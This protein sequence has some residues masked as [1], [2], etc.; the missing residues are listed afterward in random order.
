M[1][2]D[3]KGQNI[4]KE[5]TKIS[6]ET[7][8]QKKKRTERNISQDDSMAVKSS[9]TEVD[10]LSQSQ[11][12]SGGVV[13]QTDAKKTEE[14]CI[15]Q[16]K[17]EDS[18]VVAT[19]S[20]AKEPEAEVSHT[21]IVLAEEKSPVDTGKRKK[22]GTNKKKSTKTEDLPKLLRK[23]YSKRA[24]N[25]RI[26][27]RLY[28]ISDK[29][30]VESQFEEVT[31]GKKVKYM[32]PAGR[33]F[34]KADFTRLKRLAIEVKKQKGRVKWG[35]LLITVASI[36]A[37]FFVVSLF[38][39]SLIK[40]GLQKGMEAA[41]GAKCDIRYVH[42]DLLDANFTLEGMEVANKKSTMTNLFEIGR[43]TFD[44]DLMQL[45]KKKVTIDEIAIAD[46]RTGTPRKTDG[47]LPPK[48]VKEK[49]PSKLE[50]QITAMTTESINAVVDNIMGMLNQYNPQLIIDN[51]SQ[52]LSS[53][54]A[55]L[56]IGDKLQEMIPRW[57]NVP[58]QMATDLQNLIN[59][60]ESAI[61]FDWAGIQ[62]DPRK[63]TDAIAV[64]DSAIDKAM[65]L[66]ENTESTVSMLETDV[67]E[68]SSWG[69][70][71]KDAV[72]SDIALVF[73]EVDRITS[74][75]LPDGQQ[76]FASNIDL[77]LTTL[78]GEYYPKLQE[79]LGL[80]QKYSQTKSERTKAAIVKSVKRYEGQTID[81][82][83]DP[84]PTF[85][86]KK[87]HGSGADSNF[88]LA[89]DIT[90]ISNNMDKWGKPAVA[91]GRVLHGKQSDTITGT[92]DLRSYRKN[93]L[94]QLTY[95]GAG[96]DIKLG[97]P[98]SYRVPGVP[99]MEGSS[100][101]NAK[102]GADDD[103]SFSLGGSITISPIAFEV[104]PFSP[105]Y[106]HGLY[107]RTLNKFDALKA[108]FEVA[109]SSASGLSMDVTTDLD[110]QFGRAITEV[111]NEELEAI[112]K[113][114]K[115]QIDILLTEA[116][117][118]VQP[119]FDEFE[120]IKGEVEA[121][122]AKIEEYV[123]KLQQ[124]QVDAENRLKGKIEEAEAA[125]NQAV[126]D[127]MAAAEEAK[128]KAEEAAQ[129]AAEE[130]QRKAEEAAAEAKRKAE[131]AAAKAAEEAK[132]KAEEAAKDAL[133]GLFGR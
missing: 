109:Y 115:E 100:V 58:D 103:G 25:R 108:G 22:R 24:L 61:N 70:L 32:I 43:L 71:V 57:Q 59:D 5:V 131:E 73:S 106:I 76:L 124:A 19:Q 8:V 96:Y 95:S 3:E 36:F 99:S 54:D 18:G 67:D 77:F 75:K 17:A 91:V 4:D 31:V 44:F 105:E 49:E 78:L 6:P 107:T 85:L 88:S 122:A 83:I 129:R 74:F 52:N 2:K 94:F 98:E 21:E 55:V 133:K 117:K 38:K 116:A 29:K 46:V 90:D 86:I 7:A 101:I 119:L 102:I 23:K 66:K 93:D 39:D 56:E 15:D 14:N 48:P 112:K 40:S 127:T 45:L 1:K 34:S 111:F 41:F 13:A 69:N 12:K 20:E 97:L 42:L 68:V 120:R 26:L 79:A 104:D 84:H 47:A 121:Q 60:T 123:A 28:I 92:V 81:F 10:T 9:D 62:Q 27:R 113:A 82:S 65:V 33:E 16:S 50:Q 80:A 51:I 35:P 126:E 11:Q 118:K 128:R 125:I 63:I 130:A 37:V 30:Y 72:N 110:E 114:I 64:L 87:L 89:I 132:K 53:P